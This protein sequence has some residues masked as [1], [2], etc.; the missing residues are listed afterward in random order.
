MATG[1]VIAGG[2]IAGGGQIA[3]GIRA[4][5]AAKGQATQ[6]KNQARLER[7]AAEFQA[8][9]K[10]REFDKLLGRQN[11][12]IAASGIKLTGSPLLLIEETLRD[13]EETIANIRKFGA[14]AAGA[15]TSEAQNVQRAGRDAFVGSV[16]G[17]F[18]AGL[19]TA[20]KFKQIGGG[21]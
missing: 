1:A 11:L 3:G 10:A 8:I 20:S 21:A 15:L 7:E 19:S 17:G 4:R 6:L 18:G 13:K 2:V 12:S 5:N 14:A 16:I 9:Q